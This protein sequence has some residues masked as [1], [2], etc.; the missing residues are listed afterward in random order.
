MIKVEEQIPL[1][2]YVIKKYFPYL[3]SIDYEEKFQV[4]CIGLVK[5]AKRYD[6]SLGY[7]FSTYAIPMIIG[8]IKRYLRDDKWKIGS[9][10]ERINGN[11]KRPISL[12]TPITKDEKV[13]LIDNFKNQFILDNFEEKVELH[14]LINGV[15]KPKEKQVIKLNILN[16]YSQIEVSKLLGVSQVQVS[17]LKVSAL[18]KLK[19]ELS[20]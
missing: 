15:L 10:D 8:E 6:K 7:K 9:R 5:A 20:A 17:R 12:D 3:D 2:T 18:A 19:K 11:A 1:V 13:T 16:G 14:E 4:G